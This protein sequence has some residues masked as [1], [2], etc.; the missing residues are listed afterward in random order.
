MLLALQARQHTGEGQFVD[1]SMT[2]GVVSWLVTHAAPY[3]GV[4]IPQRRGQTQQTGYWPNYSVYEAKDGRFLTIAALEPWFWENLCTLLG[5]EDLIPH[6]YDEE[7]PGFEPAG[8]RN[9]GGVIPPDAPE[10]GRIPGGVVCS[11][12]KVSE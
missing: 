4:G 2:D 12:P 3:L 1:I 10:F 11:A 6:E 5:R 7:R 9:P 8:E